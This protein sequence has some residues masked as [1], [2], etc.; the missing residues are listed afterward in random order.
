MINLACLVRRERISSDM[1]IRNKLRFLDE[2]HQHQ[3]Q[4]Q[5]QLRQQPTLQNLA[6]LISQTVSSAPHQNAS[7]NKGNQSIIKDQYHIHNKSYQAHR[8]LQFN[9]Y[10]C[11][12]EYFAI[13]ILR[14]QPIQ[15]IDLGL[16]L[17]E[18]LEEHS[19]ILKH[20]FLSLKTHHHS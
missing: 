4:G 11:T 20:A 19:A 17:W 8:F 1:A 5:N 13:G 6:L 14:F 7:S 10:F 9:L 16:K 2:V 3:L 12:H 18:L 15:K